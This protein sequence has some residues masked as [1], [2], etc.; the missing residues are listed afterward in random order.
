MSASDVAQDARPE[1][2]DGRLDVRVFVP[3]AVLTVAF[4]TYGLL[5][6]ESLGT[7]SAESFGWVTRHFGWLIILTTNAMVLFCIYLACSRFARVRLGAPE[8]RPEFRTASWIAMM[9]AAG[10]GIGLIFYGVAEPMMHFTSPP[11]GVAEPE[12]EQAARAG[13]DYAIFHWGIHGW[14]IFAVAGLTFSYFGYRHGRRFLVS[15]PLRPLLGARVDGWVGHVVNSLA[16]FATLFGVIPSL[17]LGALQINGAMSRLYGVENSDTV[18]L[19]L[20]VGMMVVVILSAVTGVAKGVQF[21]ANTAMVASVLMALFMV[22]VGPSA[23][24]G[25][26]VVESMTS[27]LQNLLPM[28]ARTGTYGQG[29]WVQAWTVYYWVWWI[30]WA[31][32]VGMFIARISR[33]R[34]IRE[35]VLGVTLIPT[36]V[37]AVWFALFGGAATYLDLNGIAD[38][39]SAVAADPSTALFSVFEHYPLTSVMTTVAMVLVALFF[40]SG[41][42]AATVVMGILSTGGSESPRRPVVVFWGVA[43]AAAASVLMLA[44]GLSAIQSAMVVIC[45][46]FTAILIAMSVA[47]VKQ[48]R[49]DHPEG[50]AI[51]LV[52]R[53]TEEQAPEGGTASRGE[54][55]PI[56]RVAAV[57]P[58]P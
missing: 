26:S 52:E 19:A 45:A 4:V 55:G 49:L 10:L 18:A 23:F 36:A 3:T 53:P 46:P 8:D 24:L 44:G 40:I 5:A 6:P 25:N 54:L 12:T 47:L 2:A 48:L 16:L 37:S 31:P 30:S 38:I 42:D 1:R 32:F 11:P 57:A 7:I 50:E 17:G 56:D 28:S 43:T 21:L 51:P 29:E 35:L 39:S 15:E 27:Y 34:T 22:V 20:I 13:I 58:R 14:A 41:V 9:F 33:G